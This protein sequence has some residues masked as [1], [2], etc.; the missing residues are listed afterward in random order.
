MV[1]SILARL[2]DWH[3]A[4]PRPVHALLPAP[5][6]TLTRKAG[7]RAGAL[8]HDLRRDGASIDVRDAIQA[9]IYL[10]AG[11]TLVTRTPLTS[12]PSPTCSAPIR[13]TCS[14]DALLMT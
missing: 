5:L 2:L 9:A 11:A 12:S 10:K 7:L 13:P 1:I 6:L 8:L 3:R 14:D 4:N